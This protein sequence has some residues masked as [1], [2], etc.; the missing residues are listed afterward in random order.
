MTSTS[1]RRTAEEALTRRVRI[2]TLSTDGKARVALSE[3]AVVE[4]AEA[5][6]ASVQFPPIVVFDDGETLWL[7]DGHHRVEAARRAGFTVLRA[8][9]HEGGR[10]D[11]LL[12]ACGANATHGVRRTNAD[13]RLA[14]TLMLRDEEWRQWSSREI[15]RRCAVDEGLVRRVR[16]ELSAD[17]PQIAPAERRVRRGTA[18]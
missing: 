6:T 12:Y 7:A 17:H 9:E 18:V 15:A 3:E 14:V 1:P 4:Y 2:D 13:K 16:E 8:E 10:R 11:A 5:M